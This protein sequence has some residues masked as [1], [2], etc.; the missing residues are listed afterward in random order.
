MSHQCKLRTLLAITLV[1]TLHNLNP[2][3][4]DWSNITPDMRDNY[5]TITQTVLLSLEKLNLKLL[6]EIPTENMI[7][8]GNSVSLIRPVNP[9][10]K[11]YAEQVYG[12]MVRN[13]IREV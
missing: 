5:E 1:E 4:P 10:D 6:P 9:G 8:A 12:V 11:T 2:K 3:L 7:S 13:Y